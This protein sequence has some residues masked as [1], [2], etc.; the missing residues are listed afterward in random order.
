MAGALPTKRL[1]LF[2]AIELPEAT[3]RALVDTTVAL[4][5]AVPGDAVRWVRPEAIHLTLQFLG[6]T[7]EARLPLIHTSLR[8]AVRGDVPF[9][10]A[11]SGVG[12]FGG[13]VNLRVVWVGLGDD[14]GALTRLAE[15]VQASMEPLGYA[16]EQ[17]A[18]NG[19]LTLGRV[20]DGAS[21]DERAR[22]HDALARF[23]A[24]PI[25]SFHVQRV[26]LMQSTL[27]RGGAVYEQ[28]GAYPLA[29]VEA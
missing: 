21:R 15:R 26:S 11:P 22:L 6:E 23:V 19:H 29:G 1:R 17:R 27:G 28:L 9:D 16:R 18:F 25:P 12:S 24:P 7:D 13:R 10:V 4:R 5:R 20:R 3:L 8:M 14:G 2:V